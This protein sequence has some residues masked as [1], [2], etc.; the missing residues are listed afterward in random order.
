MRRRSVLACCLLFGAALA[1]ASPAVGQLRPLEPMDWDA[2]DHRGF[3]VSAG[4]GFYEDHRASLAGTEGRLWELG[5]VRA[6]WHAGRAAVLLE[7]TAVRVFEDQ[8]VFASPVAEARGFNGERRVDAGDQR[9][10]TLLRLT[11]PDAERWDVAL[12]FGVRLPTTDNRQ[13]LERDQT[14]FFS[15]LGLRHRSGPL[16]LMAETGLGIWGTRDENIEQVDPVLFSAEASWNGGW[17]KPSVTVVG[18]HDTRGNP[19]LRGTEDLGELRARLRV[20]RD[21]WLRL[22]VV[23]GWREFSPDF[24]LILE[25]GLR[26]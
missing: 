5:A 8:S 18:Q 22:G 15:T 24:G 7:G 17:W 4:V 13:G 6:S 26:Y 19:D 25:A 1:G 3:T 10:S 14:D 21:R 2:L 12:R 16:R 11:S 23:R 20:G 9:L